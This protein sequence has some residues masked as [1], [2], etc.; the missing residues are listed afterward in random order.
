[1]QPQPQGYTFQTCRARIVHALIVH[2]SRAEILER[3][4]LLGGRPA[5]ATELI[6]SDRS[7]A[8]QIAWILLPAGAY[9]AD[10]GAL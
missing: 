8:Y 1:M 4:D 5:P 2:Y 7:L 6:M 10:G 9:R 3:L